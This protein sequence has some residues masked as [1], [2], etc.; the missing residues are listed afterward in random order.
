MRNTNWSLYAEVKKYRYVDSEQARVLNHDIKF[1]YIQT[2][3]QLLDEIES[4][5]GIN[6]RTHDYLGIDLAWKEINRV[7]RKKR[8]GRPKLKV[9]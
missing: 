5:T 7:A 3:S 2:E 1:G 9:S 8:V 4:V 6:P